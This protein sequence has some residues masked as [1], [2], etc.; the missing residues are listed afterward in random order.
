MV[1][2][3]THF[4]HCVGLSS[5]GNVDNELVRVI[6]ELNFHLFVAA[7]VDQ[8]AAANS[9]CRVIVLALCVVPMV[10][11]CVVPM[12]VICVV[13]MVVICVVPMVVVCVIP[14]V[15]VCVIPMVVVCVIPMVVVCVTVVSILVI[16][17]LV[18]VVIFRVVT[19]GGRRIPC[20]VLLAASDLG[21]PVDAS[22]G[23]AQQGGEAVRF[24]DSQ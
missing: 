11:I 23:E 9:V 13:P 7:E 17:I 14:M 2:L 21:D 18:I 4:G 3:I 16:V 8:V 5:I 15:V 12:V 10:M 20:S 24:H 19:R 1:V 22:D 6:S